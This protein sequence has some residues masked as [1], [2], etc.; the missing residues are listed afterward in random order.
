MYDY[1]CMIGTGQ[2]Q[3]LWDNSLIYN[4]GVY[5]GGVDALAYSPGAC[6]YQND[7]VSG[8]ALATDMDYGWGLAF[9][10][11]GHQDP[12]SPD[13]NDYTTSSQATADGESDAEAAATKMCDLDL[14][15]SGGPIYGDV[16]AYGGA[17]NSTD[18]SLAE[19]YVNGWS[20][21]L[22]T[23][24]GFDSGVYGSICG[25]AIDDYK[26][27]SNVPDFIWQA[28]YNSAAAKTT[29]N[30]ASPGCSPAIPNNQWDHDQRIVQ[31]AEGRNLTI[32]GN[33]YPVDFDCALG[34]GTA[35]VDYGNACQGTQG[36]Y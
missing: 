9:I 18:L 36:N 1:Q 10:W 34:G 4:I 23:I 26:N 24:Q 2:A 27:H 15:G 11:V 29:A 12:G 14:C 35:D 33:T 19:L 22:D 7:N 16:E 17:N 3:W 21:E 32:D 6:P 30:L 20:Y 13:G 5:I 25:S 28:W 31:W 8:S